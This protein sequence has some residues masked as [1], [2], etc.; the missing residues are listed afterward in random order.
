MRKLFEVI[1]EGTGVNAYDRETWTLSV[2]YNPE[3]EAIYTIDEFNDVDMVID[4]IPEEDALA[5]ALDF[6]SC[7]GYTIV[8]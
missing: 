2:M 1:V 4:E 7:G 3:I 8:A 5:V 6:F